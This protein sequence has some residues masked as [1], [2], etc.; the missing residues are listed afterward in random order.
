MQ[1]LDAPPVQASGYIP[2]T[3]PTGSGA[4]LNSGSP[5]QQPHLQQQQQQQQQE[6]QIQP[7]APVSPEDIASMQQG[8]PQ[9]KE[10]VF[11]RLT[12]RIK[13]LERNQSLTA[14]YLEELSKRFKKQN[15]DNA[16]LAES[17]RKTMNETRVKMFQLD[18]FYR[19]ESQSLRRNLDDV[20]ER[21]FNVQLQRSLLVIICLSQ[22]MLIIGA[23]VWGKKK[24]ANLQQ[25]TIDQM[26][27]PSVSSRRQ[28]LTDVLLYH[29]KR[30][31]SDPL[32]S[33]ASCMQPLH[34]RNVDSMD[35]SAEATRVLV[36]R[37][38][39]NSDTV[40]SEK[41]KRRKEKRIK[42]Q[43]A[44]AKTGLQVTDSKL[45]LPPITSSVPLQTT[46]IKTLDKINPEFTFKMP[47]SR[48]GD[49]GFFDVP[50]TTTT[51]TKPKEN[52]DPQFSESIVTSNL[53]LPKSRSLT[54]SNSNSPTLQLRPQTLQQAK[55]TLST[56]L[57]RKDDD[58]TLQPKISSSAFVQ[59][60]II[61][62]STRFALL[63]SPT[64]ES[65]SPSP[66][67]SSSRERYFPT[68]SGNTVSV[69]PSISTPY[70]RSGSTE[71]SA[72]TGSTQSGSLSQTSSGGLTGIFN[73]GHRPAS[74]SSND[75]SAIPA[76][77]LLEGQVKKG[78]KGGL[79]AFMP[80]FFDR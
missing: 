40:P 57:A 60:P 23:I 13:N 19:Q 26:M 46:G 1:Q 52:V 8:Q 79:K 18:E 29:E 20:R 25:Q 50:K 69:P 21:L 49:N 17:N 78:R 56:S 73:N 65:H 3:L 75:S 12:N 15:E 48:S 35:S 41:A 36:M 59:D 28:T 68:L 34:S 7:P 77:A 62:T 63:A 9:Q 2:S 66:S 47:K 27:T 54:N 61:S 43:L 71:S 58:F 38:R 4:N 74:I 10:S 45:P 5:P 11:V 53:N 6:T 30:R 42:K 39:S 51:I 37:K 70:H 76:S 72:S 31:E 44:N 64:R 14:S 32:L 55:T 33:T 80:K 24:F 22:T 67:F 16:I